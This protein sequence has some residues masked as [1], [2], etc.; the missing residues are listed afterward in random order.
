MIRNFMTTILVMLACYSS[1]GYSQNSPVNE[2]YSQIEITVNINTAQADELATLLSGVGLKKAQ[3]IV[4]YRD[5][6]G[7]FQQVEDLAQVKGIGDSLV[8]KNRTRIQL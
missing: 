1:I 6:N 8:D 4:E 3:A 2:K 5:E 7:P